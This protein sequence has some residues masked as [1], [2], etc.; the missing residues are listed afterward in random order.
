M[1]KPEIARVA[2][3]SVA[4]LI[5]QWPQNGYERSPLWFFNFM[6]IFLTTG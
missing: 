6:L 4:I 3:N 1:R 5:S 2:S